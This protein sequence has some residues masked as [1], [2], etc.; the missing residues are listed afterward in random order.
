MTSVLTI[1][2]QQEIGRAHAPLHCLVTAVEQPSDG[3]GSS[4]RLERLR[5]GLQTWFSRRTGDPAEAQDLVQESLLRV[6]QRERS[7][8][9]EHLDGYAY[10]VAANL[11]TDWHRRRT[12]RQA[13]AHVSLDLA[14]MPVSGID[15]H[16]EL[17]GTSA[18]H[19]ISA[20]LDRLPE[21]TRTIFVLRRLEGLRHKE[22]AVRMGI[23]VS[24]V[25]KHMVRAAE[26]VAQ[27]MEG[28][29]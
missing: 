12:A 11:L 23:S 8:E 26:A 14:V 7:G 28:W 10:R 17:A 25:E 2:P 16:R 21:R 19:A 22:I 5:D 20:V 1:A 13:E 29:Q 4:R 6:A 18:L 24:A 27:G 3:A 9:L 15:P